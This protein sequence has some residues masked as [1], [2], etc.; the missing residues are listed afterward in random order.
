MAEQ[1]STQ[2]AGGGDQTRQW[3]RQSELLIGNDQGLDLSDFHFTFQIKHSDSSKPNTA[4]I[5][6]Y[7]LSES[8]IN[9]IRREF[10]VVMLRAGYRGNLGTIFHGTL[11]EAVSGTEGQTNPYLDIV[12]ADGD[13]PYNFATMSQTLK[14]GATVHDRVQAVL[15][16]MKPMGVTAG[17][18]ADL[19]PGASLRANVNAGMC[20][21]VL[22]DL[23]RT[24]GC[25]W[26]IQDGRL[27]IVPEKSY[28]RETVQVLT[29]E[30]GVIGR[31]EQ[32]DKGIKVKMLLNPSVKAGRL[33]YLNND[34]I[35][36]YR[37]QTEAARS[38][39][40]AGKAKGAKQAKLEP[41]LA[42]QR[43]LADNGYYY[44]M[45]AEHN[46]D[47]HKTDWYTTITCLAW[48]ATLDPPGELPS[49]LGEPNP[50][51]AK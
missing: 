11:I 38:Q 45:V 31:P 6:I 7:N 34:S 28:V 37:Y 4:K 46:G 14:K 43:K 15:A 49:Q 40:A 10:N 2:A 16:A 32:I 13:L 18:M 23:C 48:D 50:K 35:R 27:E 19:P 39:E 30:T 51:D 5:R 12:A 3:L 9:R 44:V 42:T 21:D 22:D 33:V 20:R 17:Y 25:I 8:T 36:R 1:T 24:A 47:T 41:D 29:D 26:R